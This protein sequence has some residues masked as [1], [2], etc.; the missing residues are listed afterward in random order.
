MG[1]MADES[2]KP[3]R[4][5]RWL[6]YAPRTMLVVVLVL[7]V[8]FVYVM[9]KQRRETELMNTLPAA[10]IAVR[11]GNAVTE[12]LEQDE[13]TIVHSGIPKL[14]A[15]SE[16]LFSTLFVLVNPLDMPVEYLGYWDVQGAPAGE[17]F[18][19]ASM[20]TRKRADGQWQDAS[21]S[22]C[23]TGL[24]QMVVKPGHAGR[25]TALLPLSES[26]CT[27]GIQC[28]W[29]ENGIAHSK[30]IWSPTIIAR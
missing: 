28:S 23:G 9:A 6:R 1:A 16:G 4:K 29:T 5:R 14:E 21:L 11:D 20:Q 15:A 27:I 13:P 22:W 10:A 17:I 19:F 24:G 8:W 3:K 12:A 30:T 26:D 18:P 7:S 25:F 2:N